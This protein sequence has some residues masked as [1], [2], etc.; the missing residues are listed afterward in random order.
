M[1]IHYRRQGDYGLVSAIAATLSPLAVV[2]SQWAP[3]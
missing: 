3:I 1:F 2:T